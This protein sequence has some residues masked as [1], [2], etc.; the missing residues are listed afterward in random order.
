MDVSEKLIVALGAYS[1][2]AVYLLAV[3]AAG[4]VYGNFAAV[5]LAVVSAG[6]GYLCQVSQVL[7]VAVIL[8]NALWAVSAGTAALAGLCLF[9]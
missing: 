7:P 4:L 5:M 1:L 8:I 9:F 6:L 2:G 3:V